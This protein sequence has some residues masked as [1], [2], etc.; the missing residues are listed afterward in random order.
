MKIATFTYS[1]FIM[2][3]SLFPQE[4]INEPESIGD[5]L[6]PDP[7]PFT[8]ETVGWKFL[9]VLLFIVFIVVLYKQVKLYVK[10]SYRR[11]AIKKIALIKNDNSKSHNQINNLN[12]VLKQVA[13]AT[14]GRENVAELYGNDW[15]LFLD[16]KSKKSNF[17]KNEK[18]FTDAIYKNKDVDSTILKEIYK[19][20]VNWINTHA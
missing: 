2:F 5:I 20:T 14:Y 18:Y 4:T 1:I 9:A 10:N 13:I 6:E 3:M 8:F 16:S 17:V 7:L 11:V 15:F 12:I 19:T